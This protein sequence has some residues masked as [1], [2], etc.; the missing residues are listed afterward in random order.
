LAKRIGSLENIKRES[1]EKAAKGIADFFL[2]SRSPFPHRNLLKTKDTPTTI[3]ICT[4]RISMPSR[5]GPMYGNHKPGQNVNGS[6]QGIENK[7]P[8]G[9]PPFVSVSQAYWINGNISA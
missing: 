1:A 2:T 4:N 8:Y 7:S 6:F 3:T 5:Y 9:F